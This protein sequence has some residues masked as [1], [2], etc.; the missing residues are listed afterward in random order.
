M[1]RVRVQDEQQ[2]QPPVFRGW[3]RCVNTARYLHAAV[4]CARVT[5]F[6]RRTPVAGYTGALL[7]AN[8]DV[9]SQF[10]ADVA[11]SVLRSL[12]KAPEP[13]D[14]TTA[15]DALRKLAAEVRATSC[16]TAPIR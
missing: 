15:D 11:R 14:A 9:A 1:P 4:I 2:R 8:T 16:A 3:R 7:Y 12:A 6:V 10:A 13:K 5:R